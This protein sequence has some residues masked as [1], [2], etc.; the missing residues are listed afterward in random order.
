[1]FLVRGCEFGLIKSVALT[2]NWSSLTLQQ[3]REMWIHTLMTDQTNGKGWNEVWREIVCVCVQTGDYGLKRVYPWNMKQLLCFFL[4]FYMLQRQYLCPRQKYPIFPFYR[5]APS[6]CFWNR[7]MWCGTEPV[8]GTG[9]TFML[10]HK[11]RKLKRLFRVD[12]ISSFVPWS[13]VEIYRD[14]LQS[15]SSRLLVVTVRGSHPCRDNRFFSSPEPSRPSLETTEPPIRWVTGLFG[16]V[17]RPGHEVNHAPP[18]SAVS[19]TIVSIFFRECHRHFVGG[20]AMNRLDIWS[21]ASR[22]IVSILSRAFR[23]QLSRNYVGRLTV[24]YLD[25]CRAYRGQ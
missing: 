23:G 1:M 15:R 24:I 8:S 7:E 6:R 25:I 12:D 11:A 16:G 13:L 4:N 9:I 2:S 22:S 17:K 5:N 10:Q 20:F 21:G 18:T 3:T 19:R 14:L